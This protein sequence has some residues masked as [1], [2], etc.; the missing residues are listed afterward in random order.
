MDG[1]TAGG[2]TVKLWASWLLALEKSGELSLI[3]DSRGRS[4]ERSGG[5]ESWGVEKHGDGLIDWYR[6][7]KVA[8]MGI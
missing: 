2:V 7:R 8:K 1:Q 4:D 6:E 3:W 5:D